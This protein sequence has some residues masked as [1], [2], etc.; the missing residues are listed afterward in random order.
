ML[1]WYNLKG[2]LRLLLSLNKR[3]VQL[4]GAS[5]DLYI[6]WGNRKKV[7]PKGDCN[8]LSKLRHVR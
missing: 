4:Y 3:L 8:P 1:E 7:S 2:K 5:T 6:P